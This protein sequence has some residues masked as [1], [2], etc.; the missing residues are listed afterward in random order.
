VS[1]EVCLTAAEAAAVERAANYL[2]EAH[3]QPDPAA[4]GRTD[5]DHVTEAD[6]D[7]LVRVIRKI[8]RP[9]AKAGRVRYEAYCGGRLLKVYGQVDV[10][11]AEKAGAANGSEFVD[12]QH[13]W[14][15]D[16][17]RVAGDVAQAMLAAAGEQP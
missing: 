5:S 10:T 2:L 12:G 13:W 7:A 14:V 8:G 4:W 6:L 3:P 16:G 11:P 9:A 1:G 17:R 15:I